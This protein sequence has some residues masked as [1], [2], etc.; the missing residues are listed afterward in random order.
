MKY[1]RVVNEVIQEII[2]FDPTGYYP[3]SIVWTEVPEESAVGDGYTTEGGLV[4]SDISLKVIHIDENFTEASIVEDYITILRIYTPE[5]L[6]AEDAWVPVYTYPD[7]AILEAFPPTNIDEQYI[8]NITHDDLTRELFIEYSYTENTNE[9]RH[10]YA[11]DKINEVCD[12]IL[13]EGMRVINNFGNF[14]GTVTDASGLDVTDNEMVIGN[15]IEICK[16]CTYVYTLYDSGSILPDQPHTAKVLD[17]ALW[18]T[19]PTKTKSK[20]LNKVFNDVYMAVEDVRKLSIEAAYNTG[21]T[22]EMYDMYET[23][24][25]QELATARNIEAGYDI[26]NGEYVIMT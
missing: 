19:F 5:M 3:P 9:D 1:A 22:N 8:S 14:G 20:N 2:T 7:P 16:L 17:K 15:I 18:I 4:V 26:V 6:E 11:I 25:K 13:N 23:A 10:Q 24:V 21:Y 12:D